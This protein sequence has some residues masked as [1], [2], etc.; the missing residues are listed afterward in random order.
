LCHGK[1]L[2][3]EGGEIEMVSPRKFRCSECQHSWEVPHGTGR[4]GACP[5]CGS[6]NI[7]RDEED[8]GH[9]CKS[10]Q[11]RGKCRRAGRE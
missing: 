7:H 6:S 11:A 9:G 8:R 4:P 1:A 3:L 10:G 5:Q 2:R